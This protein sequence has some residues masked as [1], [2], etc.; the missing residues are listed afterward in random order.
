MESA[1]D[2]EAAERAWDGINMSRSGLCH[3]GM[4]KMNEMA[5]TK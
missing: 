1:N 4:G 5:K 3:L 2:Q